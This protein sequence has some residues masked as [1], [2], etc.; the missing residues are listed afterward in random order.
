MRTTTVASSI[1]ALFT[2]LGC[3]DAGPI[4]LAAAGPWHLAYTL[5]THQGIEL[6]ASEINAAGGIGGRPLEIRWADDGASAHDA[7]STAERLVADRAVLGVIG[8]MNS[9]PMLAAAPIYDGRL[10]AVSPA[11]T[12]PDLSGISPWAFRII[13]SDS[14]N[15]ATLARFAADGLGARQAAVLYENDAYGRGLARAFR[16]GFSGTV[17]FSAPIDGNAATAGYEPYVATLARLHPDV[18]FVAG[19]TASGTEILREAKH[20]RLNAAFIG[21]DGWTGINSDTAD[22]E[23]VYM[24]TPFVNSD[25]RTAVQQFVSAFQARY[26]TMPEEDA[27]LAYDATRLLATAIAAAGPHRRAMRD[28]L[29][30]LDAAHAYVGVTGAYHFLPSGDPADHPFVVARIHRGALV[31]T[32]PR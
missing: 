32:P 18:V 5:P 4:V 20:Q 14:V 26:H 31:V 19:M 10:V 12:S 22:A 11:A 7:V 13:T 8:H 16:T 28:Y 2:V 30:R 17:S 23:N 29:A 3:H 25:A 6:A 27:A 1:V 9:D 21:G 15:G 24:A